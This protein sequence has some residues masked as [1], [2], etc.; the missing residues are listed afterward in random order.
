[1]ASGNATSRA[2]IQA[3]RAIGHRATATSRANAECSDG[4]AATGLPCASNHRVPTSMGTTPNP[5]PVTRP[6]PSGRTPTSDAYH[7]GA[8]GTRM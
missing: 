8:A 3:R 6:T 1:M 2:R 7:G 4:S 5:K